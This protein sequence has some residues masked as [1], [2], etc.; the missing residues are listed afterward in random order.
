MFTRRLAPLATPATGG[1]RRGTLWLVPAGD[2][3]PRQN[4]P[5]LGSRW[6]DDD[7]SPLQT[8]L[9]LVAGAG[10]LATR[11]VIRQRQNR[12]EREALRNQVLT[13]LIAAVQRRDDVLSRASHDLKTPL[14]TVKGQAQLL[15]RFL[16]AI[17][18]PDVERVRASLAEIDAAATVAAARIDR[19]TEEMRPPSLTTPG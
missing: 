19:L 11:L 2:A 12:R 6:P 7:R 4:G 14:T 17:D 5:P 18:G 16:R 15:Q 8:A 3:L 1:T 9:V 13:D 10:M